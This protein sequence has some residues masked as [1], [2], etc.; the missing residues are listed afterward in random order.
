MDT[1]KSIKL[2]TDAFKTIL[3]VSGRA[4]G[5]K[6]KPYDG[7]SDDAEG[8]QW[9]VATFKDKPERAR[10]GVNLEGMK[11]DDWPIA[12]FIEGEL[13]SRALLSLPV[14][15]DKIYIGFFRDAWQVTNRPAIEERSLGC[16]GILLEEMTGFQ[17]KK[18]LDEAYACLDPQNNHRGRAKQ[19]VTLS[20]SGM[21][22]MMEV[23]PHLQIYTTIWSNFPSDVE[24]A[25][26]LMQKGFDRLMP[27]YE[28]VRTCVR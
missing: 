18:T 26:T 12:R 22:K 24:E 9:N 4:F 13:K 8:V 1:E 23:S 21:L 14:E 15:K 19:E 16:S 10:L 2:L 17:W 7:M 25:K 3:G 20:K 27:V 11:Y 5:D 6:S 28:Y